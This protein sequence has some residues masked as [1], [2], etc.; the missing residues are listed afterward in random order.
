MKLEFE[1][2][3]TENGQGYGK[4]KE[5]FRIFVDITAISKD[6]EKIKYAVQNMA[7]S[8]GYKQISF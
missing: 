1:K 6:A 8:L 4:I 7:H 5:T 3:I 2:Y